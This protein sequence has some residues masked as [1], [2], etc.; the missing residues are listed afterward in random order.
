VRLDRTYQLN[1]GGNADFKNMLE[2]ERLESKK[3]SK[4]SGTSSW[5][6]TARVLDSFF[7]SSRSRSSMFLKSALPPKYRPQVGAYP[8]GGHRVRRSAAQPRTEAGGVGLAELRRHR[9]DMDVVGVERHV[10]LARD[11]PGLGQLLRFEPLAL[12]HISGW[13]A[14]RS[15]ECRSTSN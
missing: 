14:P 5:L 12:Q 15:A 3:L 1:F 2:R 7:D 4:T 13:R 11:G 8:A 10:E 9:P 6:V